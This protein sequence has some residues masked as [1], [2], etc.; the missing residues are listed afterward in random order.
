MNALSHPFAFQALALAIKEAKLQH[1]DML[2]TKAVVYRETEP[3]PEE[4]DKK[5]Q[6]GGEAARV[7]VHLLVM[8]V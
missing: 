8:G 4:R 6:V 7:D 2:V 3:S 5:P 1:P